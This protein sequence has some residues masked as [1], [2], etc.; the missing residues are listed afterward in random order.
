MDTLNSWDLR[1][2]P[3]LEW[4]TDAGKQYTFILLDVGYNIMQGMYIDITG[5]DISTGTVS[6]LIGLET[7]FITFGW[8]NVQCILHNYN[9]LQ[10]MLKTLYSS[11]TNE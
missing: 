5:N 3:T 2:L 6:Y 11:D 10:D 1:A 9:I 8:F 7:D 4:A